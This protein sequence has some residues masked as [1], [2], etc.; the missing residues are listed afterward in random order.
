MADPSEPRRLLHAFSSFAVGGPQ[1]R[2]CDIANALGADYHH[3]LVAMDD[4]FE[5]A[6]RLREEVIWQTVRVR[7]AKNR[8]IS[9]GNLA[10]FRKLLST[11]RPDLLV[12]YN[13]GALEW[14]L[15]NRGWPVAP[16]L[17]FEDGFG[18]EESEV[19]LR[20]RVHLRRLVL[21]RNSRVVVP[22]QT[23]WAAATKEWRLSTDRVFLIPNGIDCERFAKSADRKALRRFGIAPEALVI[24]TVAALRPEKNLGR[25]ITAFAR[26]GADFPGVLVLVGEG[27]EQGKLEQLA[28][29]SGI[30]SRIHFAGAVRRPEE[31]YGCFDI[32]AMSSDTEQMPISVVEAMATGLPVI[33]T[34]VGDI[35]R[36]VAP[37]NRFLIEGC[38]DDE[39]LARGLVMLASDPALRERL[40]ACNRSRARAE[41][42][43]DEMLRSYRRL[44]NGEAIHR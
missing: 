38:R 9:L 21:G 37:E 31:L 24:G 14:G 42:G 36:I 18:P 25:L 27:R 43:I 16:H 44:L 41:F 19:Q 3:F 8:G 4:D 33:A 35:A 13:F 1:V 7:V 5:C 6:V 15:A 23:L 17:H 30:T 29:A 20:R 32:F 26:L 12:T 2:F 34:D 28:M 39:A 11:V 10:R 40:G 22:S